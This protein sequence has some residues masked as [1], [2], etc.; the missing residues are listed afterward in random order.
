MLVSLT[1]SPLSATV[2][3]TPGRVG[4]TETSRVWNRKLVA[5]AWARDRDQ[6][7]PHHH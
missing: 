3:L 5:C 4:S 2:M 1:H 6:E 7:R